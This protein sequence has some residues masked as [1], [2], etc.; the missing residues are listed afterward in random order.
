MDTGCEWHPDD[1]G[2]V[3]LDEALR[4][5]AQPGCM[6]PD[7]IAGFAAM[8]VIKDKHGHEL[9][10]DFD[11]HGRGGCD[12]RNSPEWKA[13]HR[14]KEHK[15]ADQ[16]E[17]TEG[18]TSTTP[19]PVLLASNDTL[20][21]A[22]PAAPAAPVTTATVGVDQAVA[23]MKALLPAGADASPG[24]LIGGAAG[25]AVVGAAVKF[26]P[27]MMKAR[28]ERLA[29]EKEQ[30]HEEKMKELEIKQEQQQKQDDQHGKCSTERVMLEA[31]VVAQAS[32]IE[33]LMAQMKDIAAKAEKAE[34]AAAAPAPASLDFDPE[35]LEAL[36]ARI[37]RIEDAG[38]PAKPAKAAKSKPVAKGKKKE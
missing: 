13:E 1:A 4:N 23:Q 9:D 3:P 8:M 22:L 32:Q 6:L 25:L 17:H 14:H 11:P 2:Y 28:A 20:P 16:I 26:G 30:A 5:L 35:A 12:H 31:K 24:L 21:S 19:V 10:G 15:M 33:L 29:Q 18:T 27:G 34:K 36:E 37:A 7:E 38:K